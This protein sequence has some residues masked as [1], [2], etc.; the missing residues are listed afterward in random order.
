VVVEH[1]AWRGKLP[2]RER[3]VPGR[4]WIADA[5]HHHATVIEHSMILAGTSDVLTMLRIAPREPNCK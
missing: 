4:T 1:V 3:A 5:A 2:A